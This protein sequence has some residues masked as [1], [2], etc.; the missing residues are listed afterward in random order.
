[1]M[2]VWSLVSSLAVILSYIDKYT[3]Q[4][5]QY[6]GKFFQTIHKSEFYRFNP[7]GAILH[8]PK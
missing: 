2:I 1:M 4:I 3:N 5:Y 8:A 7:H 6:S